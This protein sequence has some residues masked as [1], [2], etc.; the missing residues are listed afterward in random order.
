MMSDI[1]FK[2][3]A[4]KMFDIKGNTNSVLQT[5]PVIK[6]DAPIYF[7]EIFE[8]INANNN[9][10]FKIDNKL[11]G[12][13]NLKIDINI[14]DNCAIIY[15][16]RNILNENIKDV[17]FILTLEELNNNFEENKKYKNLNLYK[18]EYSDWEESFKNEL[19]YRLSLPHFGLKQC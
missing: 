3:Y 16:D 12:D 6:S 10:N 8:N 2:K 19:Y 14:L 18:T 5:S 1:Y 9:F 13:F 15:K 17:L 11:N 4:I 7:K